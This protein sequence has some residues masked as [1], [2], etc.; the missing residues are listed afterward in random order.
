MYPG[1][2]HRVFWY[3]LSYM[4]RQLTESPRISH[5]KFIVVSILSASLETKAIGLEHNN[6]RNNYAH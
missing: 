5:C 4:G 2:I 3:S 1:V 6:F